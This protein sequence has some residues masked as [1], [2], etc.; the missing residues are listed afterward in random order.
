MT[1]PTASAEARGLARAAKTYEGAGDLDSARKHY[2]L[3]AKRY[4]D[5]SKSTTDKTERNTQHDLA[6]H[7]LAKAKAIEQRL[8]VPSSGRD[9]RSGK[10][11]RSETEIAA[12]KLILKEKPDIGFSDIG[13]LDQVKEEIKRVIIYPFAHKDLYTFYGQPAGGGILLYGP[14]GCGKTMMAKASAREC[15]ADFISIKTSDIVS[16]WVG[17]S[18]KTIREIFDTAHG[19][20]R[21]II[22]FD[23][24]DSVAGRRS[25]SEDYARRVVNELLSEMDGVGATS[26]NLLVLAATNA[27]WGIDPALRR[28]GR[29]DKMILIPPPDFAARDAIFRIHLK[30][31][32]I[33]DDVD[34]NKLAEISESFSGA[35]IGAICR[36]A[37]DI[38]LNEV[39]GG[40][41]MRKIEIH[42]FIKVIKGR[43]SSIIPWFREAVTQIKASGEEDVFSDILSF[44]DRYRRV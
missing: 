1:S 40:G 44:V 31:R 17:E 8:V 30:D 7:L 15:D 3:A 33:A 28:P 41:D 38:P 4:D 26:G 39:I 5:A 21:A 34:V 27:P 22:F 20:E 6:R 11:S 19:C 14:P 35:D 10:E 18:E 9:S 2:L 42:D 43:K 13:G 23:E 36:D 29:F 12:N 32:P 16:K 24:I 37:A 25:E